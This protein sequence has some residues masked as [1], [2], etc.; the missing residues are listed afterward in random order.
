[1]QE[2]IVIRFEGEY[3]HVIFR[4]GSSFEE[5]L[6]LWKQVEAACKKHNC[7]N[8]L[9]EGYSKQPLKTI[10]GFQYV[11]I[12]KKAGVTTK[13][14]IAWVKHTKEGYEDLEFTETVLKNH[15]ML[16]GGLFKTVAQAKSWLLM[17]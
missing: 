6:S 2:N 14:R 9:G 13:H 17:S 10:G 15:C 3:V 12:F 16:R 1:M 4:G 11:E 5:N 7:H 8:I